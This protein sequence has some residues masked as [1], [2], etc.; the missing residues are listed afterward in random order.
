MKKTRL[1]RPAALAVCLLLAGL[2]AGLG[3]TLVGCKAQRPV[4]PR[5]EPPG[6]PIIL[7]ALTIR[8]ETYSPEDVPEQYRAAE[9]REGR[10]YYLVHMSDLIRSTWL[11]NLEDLDLSIAGYLSNNTLII[12]MT[13]AVRDE[14]KK[15]SFVKWVGLYQPYF[16]FAPDIQA[17]GI[18]GSGPQVDVSIFDPAAVSQ[19]SQQ[20]AG[21]GMQVTAASAD[22]WRGKLRIVLDPALLPK[23]AALPEVEWIEPAA[24]SAATAAPAADVSGASFP[25]SLYQLFGDAYT[26][27][28]RTYDLGLVPWAPGTAQSYVAAASE[29]DRFAWDHKDWLLAMPSGN[30]GRDSSGDGVSDAGTM[31]PAAAAKNAL[32]AGDSV[33]S[34]G[35]SAVAPYSGRGPA[36]DSRIK[37]DLVAMGEPAATVAGGADAARQ[38]IVQE[39]GMASPSGA[40]LRAILVNGASAINPGDADASPIPNSAQGW[41][42]VNLGGVLHP[43][44]M[45]KV[46]DNQEGM[47]TGETRT[48]KVD[49][50]GEGELR[51]TLAW[52]DYPSVPEAGLNLVNDLDLRVIGPGNVY[53]YPNG[54]NSRDPLNNL[55]RVVVPLAGQAGE[56]TIEM[57]AAN[58]PFGPQPF[59]LVAT[60]L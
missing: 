39:L 28:S 46:L 29:V 45:L 30:Q 55:E 1:F 19:V 36:A 42:G 44:A 4:T 27:G 60:Q 43:G 56:Y 15:L 59:A 21:L 50:S 24:V 37:P 25:L 10:A 52:T 38:A 6:L 14:V 13:P 40:L 5:V 51:V 3:G 11:Q 7:A 2:G 31:Q 33:A 26:Q 22:T 18:S 49:V 41:G 9:P 12:G 57:T 8:T 34:G 16:K 20:I 58:V 53:Y 54:R 17:L 48:Y 47:G 32:V 23:L 35:G